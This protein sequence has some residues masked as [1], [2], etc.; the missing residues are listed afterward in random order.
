MNKERVEQKCPYCD[1]G[2]PPLER[3]YQHGFNAFESGE[4]HN[5]NELGVFG[6]L[7][8]AQECLRG[9][10]DAEAFAGAKQ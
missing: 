3:A 7:E 6:T 1:E 9:W 5:T 8:E 10:Y 2:K 4:F